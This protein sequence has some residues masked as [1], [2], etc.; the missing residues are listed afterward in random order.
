M[1]R[2][3]LHLRTQL[4]APP[5]I[6]PPLRRSFLD[7]LEVLRR[8]RV[9]GLSF[10]ERG[11]Y[12]HF[13]KRYVSYCFTPF[14]GTPLKGVQVLGFLETR[15]LRFERLYLLDANE[16]VIPDT[17]REETFLP[18]RVREK[19]G[20]PTYA[21]RDAVAA[22]YFETLVK[23]SGEAHVFF[24]END[25]KEKSRFVERLLWERQKREQSARADGYVRSVGYRINLE[26]NEPPPVAKTA[27]MAAFLARRRYDATSLNTYLNCPLQFYY[28]HVLGLAR[29]EDASPDIERVDIGR[30]VH[31]VSSH[32]SRR[33]AAARS[34]RRTST[35]R[36]WRPSR[37][38]PSRRP[39]AR[40]RRARPT[41]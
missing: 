11:C 13:L 37:T 10:A 7:N 19:L 2:S 9:A 27:A 23:G 26:Q 5:P 28:R 21:E 14:E 39:T 17:K 40:N 22:Y 1:R 12:F 8:S 3:S 31:E 32:T 34:P 33:G 38:A 20:L 6:L 4:R 41:S 25:R 18:L 36:I 30:L 15:A 29:K 16:D 24:V 35:G